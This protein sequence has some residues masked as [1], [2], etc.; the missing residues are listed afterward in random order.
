MWQLK[1]SIIP[2][3]VAALG[4][5]KKGTAKHLEKI[6]GKQNLPEVVLTSTAHILRKAISI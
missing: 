1:T 3:N 4:L 2:I 6:P 5:V